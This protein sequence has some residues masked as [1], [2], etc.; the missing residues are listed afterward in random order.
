MNSKFV[1]ER[2][3][4][5]AQRLLRSGTEETA[6]VKEAFVAVLGREPATA[7][8]ASSLS[9][10]AGF[11]KLPAN[12]EGRLAAWTSLCRALMAS[13]DFMYVQ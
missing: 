6:R 3:K 4:V 13:N 9:Y 7:E 1:A 10:L 12:D 11:P 5:L 2:A 8:T